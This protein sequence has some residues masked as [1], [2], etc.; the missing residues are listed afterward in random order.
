MLL[1]HRAAPGLA[2]QGGLP[3]VGQTEASQASAGVALAV[4]EAAGVAQAVVTVAG[5][6]LAIVEGAAV[7][8]AVVAVANVALALV[9]GTWQ[10]AGVRASELPALVDVGGEVAT[11]YTG[12]KQGSHV[13]HLQFGAEALACG[14]DKVE[15]KHGMHQGLL[16]AGGSMAW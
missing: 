3:P 12:I 11:A 4:V 2:M 5:V 15:R 13:T 6:A 9:L 7:A 8:L 14:V 1:P 10:A 16:A